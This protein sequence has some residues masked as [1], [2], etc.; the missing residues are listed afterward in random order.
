MPGPRFGGASAGVP[1]CVGGALTGG[2]LGAYFRERSPWHV[3]VGSLLMAVAGTLMVLLV[4]RSL[5]L[6]YELAPQR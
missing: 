4:Y 2:L 1:L 3:D 5:A 6:R